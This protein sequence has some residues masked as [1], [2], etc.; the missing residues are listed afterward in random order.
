MWW[1]IAAATLGID[2]G[3]QPTETGGVEC[4]I[5]IEPHALEGLRDGESLITDV[6]PW[7]QGAER[8]R[9]VV[10]EN[11]LPRSEIVVPQVQAPVISARPEV[12][13]KR[14]VAKPKTSMSPAESPSNAEATSDTDTRP[15]D[16]SEDVA[17]TSAPS[18][19]TSAYPQIDRRTRLPGPGDDDTWRPANDTTADART[20]A[21]GS[22]A[23][24]STTAT[25]P[26][27]PTDPGPVDEEAAADQDF[28]TDE[29]HPRFDRPQTG[30]T[31]DG[32]T[33]GSVTGRPSAGRPLS[34]GVPPTKPI[35]DY[36]SRND[37]SDDLSSRRR[38]GETDRASLDEE[39]PIAEKPRGAKI[40][41]NRTPRDETQ[42]PP[43]DDRTQPNQGA[44]QVAEVPIPWTAWTLA[45][46]GLFVSLG[47]NL[48]LGWMTHD[49][50]RRYFEMVR[51]TSALLE[52][53]S[54]I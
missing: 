35:M 1:F 45:L 33:S 51:H 31:A 29:T 19:R 12:P 3:W 38:T 27:S 24:G 23:P 40:Q 30:S 8:W 4:I 39:E 16:S 10:G 7:L 9:F 50:H 6:P 5:Q 54:A 11:E 21:P 28:A 41:A 44:S 32:V 25:T 20:S 14:A 53:E 34:D 18:E 43:L 22:V 15:T 2:V 48:Y 13:E 26:R 46:L 36:S 47:G 42:A 37:S 49:L 52:R 17:E